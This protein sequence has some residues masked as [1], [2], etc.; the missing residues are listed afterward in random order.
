MISHVGCPAL[1][2]HLTLE[3]SSSLLRSREISGP[4]AFLHSLSPQH[5]AFFTVTS[6]LPLLLATTLTSVIPSPRR[7]SSRMILCSA[8]VSSSTQAQ[9]SSPRLWRILAIPCNCPE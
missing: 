3:T 5:A 7:E 1:F 6:S 4:T 2:P 9:T 8:L